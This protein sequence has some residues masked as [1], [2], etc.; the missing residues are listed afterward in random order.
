LVD[1]GTHVIKIFFEDSFVA[2]SFAVSASC[3][4]EQREY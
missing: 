3:H 2:R 1:G 4:E